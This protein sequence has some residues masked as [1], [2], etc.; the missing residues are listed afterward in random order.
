[1]NIATLKA[2]LKR[3]QEDAPRGDK[4]ILPDASGS[5]DAATFEEVRK[6]IQQNNERGY[7][8][9]APER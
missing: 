7:G 9:G 8:F 2:R 6:T 4:T 3:V 1:M 5:I